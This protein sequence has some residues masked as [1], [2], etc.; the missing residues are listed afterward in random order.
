MWATLKGVHVQQVPGMRF[1]TYNDLFSTVK[2]PEKTLSTVASR[3]EE[4]MAH[5]V[6]VCPE[7]IMEVSTSP[8]GGTTQTTPPLPVW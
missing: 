1:S 8:G 7:Q 4:A 6:E 3:V 2:G 5:V